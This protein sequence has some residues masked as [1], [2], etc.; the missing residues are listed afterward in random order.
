MR[1]QERKTRASGPFGNLY[2]AY[3]GAYPGWP[4]C[5]DKD[6][7]PKCRTEN[8]HCERLKLFIERGKAH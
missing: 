2:E 6:C 7:L 8:G 4:G 1:D 3:G 5:D